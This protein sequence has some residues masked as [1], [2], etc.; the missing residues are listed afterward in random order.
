MSS[1]IENLLITEPVDRL[2]RKRPRI[3]ELEN[4]VA[5]GA[6]PQSHELTNRVP[7]RRC[8][9]GQREGVRGAAQPRDQ[10]IHIPPPPAAANP[11]TIF[12]YRWMFAIH[13]HRQQQ[14]WE[15][16][17]GINGELKGSPK[18]AI[19]FHQ[20]RR[21]RALVDLVFDHSDSAPV[22]VLEQRSRA[23]DQIGIGSN[24]LPIDAHATGRRFLTKPP[25]GECGNGLTLPYEEKY[26]HARPHHAL[27]Q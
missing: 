10:L 23:R 7:P 14:V 8:I 3:V 26:A 21:S 2:A 24:A 27:L 25:V 1:W 11:Y 19:D 18:P 4:L 22:E 13:R 12:R 16:N 5:I 9:L 6:A 17:A 20:I 15:I